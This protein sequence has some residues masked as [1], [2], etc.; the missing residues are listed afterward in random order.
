[1]FRFAFATWA[2]VTRVLPARCRYPI[3]LISCLKGKALE[4]LPSIFGYAKDTLAALGAIL[5]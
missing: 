2:S 4:T 5:V 3:Q 1:M